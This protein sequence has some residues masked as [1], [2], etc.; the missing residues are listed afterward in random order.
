MSLGQPRSDASDSGPARRPAGCSGGIPSGA[1]AGRSIIDGSV[2][3]PAVGPQRA[4]AVANDHHLAQYDEQ[5]NTLRAMQQLMAQ[6]A[7]NC[8]NIGKHRSQRSQT[9]DSAEKPGSGGSRRRRQLTMQ[10]PVHLSA[11]EQADVQET[12]DPRWHHSSWQDGVQS[13]SYMAAGGAQG[14]S[15]V[16]AAGGKVYAHG[17]V[18]VGSLRTGLVSQ[19]AIGS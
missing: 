19:H 9:D 13:P 11:M 16:T 6:E 15:F 12:L 3:D 5:F 14:A 4:A 1:P 8:N 10:E 17:R 18:S 2:C 7:H